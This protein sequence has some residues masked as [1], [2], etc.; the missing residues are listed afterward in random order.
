MIKWEYHRLFIDAKHDDVPTKLNEVGIRGWEMA[1]IIP[2]ENTNFVWFIFK[3]VLP[4]IP[5]KA[6][7]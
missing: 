7:P 6:Q 5:D 3:R 1:G 4:S 2:L